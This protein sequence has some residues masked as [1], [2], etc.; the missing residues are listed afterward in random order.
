MKSTE[1]KLD[2]SEGD[3][4]NAIAVALAEAFTP[5]KRDELLRDLIRAMLTQKVSNYGKE[6]FLS[7]AV[8]SRIKGMVE[9]QLSAFVERLRPDVDLL[10]E[11]ALGPQFK[12][13]V[14]DGVKSGLSRIL[15][16]NVRVD[17]KLEPKHTYNED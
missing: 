7:Q 17:V 2:L 4:N 13:N 5:Q 6:T 8:Q 16:E 9:N 12:A 10:V 14:L 15:L 1:L 3:I 11:E